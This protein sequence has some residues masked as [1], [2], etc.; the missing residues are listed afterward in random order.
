MATQSPNA[1]LSELYQQQLSS[2]QRAFTLGEYNV[3]YHA[4][5]AALHCAET[6][7]DAHGLSEVKQRA[8]EQLVW[9]E[10]HHP[11]YEHSTQSAIRR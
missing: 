5:M 10:Q 7:K 1:E 2:N 3:A 4:L 6:L 11:E 9:I 8:E